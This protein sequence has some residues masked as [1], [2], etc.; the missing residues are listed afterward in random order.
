MSE[1]QLNPSFSWSNQRPKTEQKTKNVYRPTTRA[2]YISKLMSKPP[3]YH[4]HSLQNTQSSSLLDKQWHL[5]GLPFQTSALLLS[6][7]KNHSQPL[8]TLTQNNQQQNKQ[9][10]QQMAVLN[11]TNLKFHTDLMRKKQT[12][13]PLERIAL[14]AQRYFTF[15][16]YKKFEEFFYNSFFEQYT[17]FGRAVYQ[18]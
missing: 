2:G 1:L 3:L 14:W 15:F 12:L 11:E 9:T 8:D 6:K 18:Q 7:T 10:K 17:L 4:S 5:Y 13:S 16:L